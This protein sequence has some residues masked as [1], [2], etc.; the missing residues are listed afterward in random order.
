MVHTYGDTTRAKQTEEMCEKT[1][2][3]L[4]LGWKDVEDVIPMNGVQEMFLK[5]QR[6]QSN[7]HRHAWFCSN[8]SISELQTALE[9][10]LAHHSIFRSI[11]LYFNSK[12]PLHITVRPSQT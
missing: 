5:K 10:A 2:K 1:L 6:P 8:T 11:A 7:N 9:G 12:T 4:E 3:P